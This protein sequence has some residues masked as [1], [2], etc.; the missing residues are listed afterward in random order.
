M[1]CFCF[2]FFL[3][4]FT[5]VFSLI[6]LAEIVIAI[7]LLVEVP[8]S[9][10]VLKISTILTRFDHFVLGTLLWSAIAGL[11]RLGC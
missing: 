6:F 8:G 2:T 3:F 10:V 4:C 5:L 11:V 7:S 9:S 1:L